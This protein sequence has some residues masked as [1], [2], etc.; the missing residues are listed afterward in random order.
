MTGYYTTC[1]VKKALF[2]LV[3][4]LSCLIISP[5]LAADRKVVLACP[6]WPPYT[7]KELP[8]QGASS[9]VVRQAFK[10]MGYE[11]E[12]R[13]LPWNRVLSEVRNQTDIDGYFPEYFSEE[14][15]KVFLFSESIG[16][17]PV[18]F[19]RRTGTEYDWG[20][21]ADLREHTIG[22]VSGYVNERRFD[23]MVEEGEID[24]ESVV[25]DLF[26]LRKVLA[27]RVD[28]AVVDS[29]TFAYLLRTDPYLSLRR[30]ELEMAPRLLQIQNLYSCFRKSERGRELL[31]V[32]NE[33]LNKIA[34][35][36]IQRGYFSQLGLDE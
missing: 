36:D 1:M 18:G 30:K 4:L 5:G 22:V 23:V 27:G 16:K 28:L 19:V 9:A 24:T 35:M 26:N 15:D 31:E 14:R 8:Q 11:L 2:L 21:Y 32:F 12:I 6:E 20:S 25:M 13:F 33:G 10:V 3:Y 17:G 34:P 29:N 7:G